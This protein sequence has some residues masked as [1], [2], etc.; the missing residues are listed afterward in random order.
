VDQFGY[1]PDLPKVAILVHPERGWNAADAYEPGASL[2][3]RKWA[4]GAVVFKGAPQ[5]WN[6]GKVDET[7]GDRGSWFDFSD[8]REPGLYYVFDPER[9]ERSHPF[10]IDPAVYRKVLVTA[11]RM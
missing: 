7:A 1:R 5:V 11:Q 3:V 6:G 10:E 4:D 8:V 9:G 2:E